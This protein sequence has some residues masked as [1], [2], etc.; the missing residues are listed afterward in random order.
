MTAGPATIAP[1]HPSSGV[2]N[3]AV[4][5]PIQINP[6]LSSSKADLLHNNRSFLSLQG[7]S[8]SG[9]PSQASPRRPKPLPLNRR[10][11]PPGLRRAPVGESNRAHQ[12]ARLPGGGHQLGGGVGLGGTGFGFG[13]GLLLLSAGG[14]CIF[15]GRRGDVTGLVRV[16]CL[17]TLGKA[18][19]AGVSVLV[20]SLSA[21][22]AV[23][24]RDVVFECG[25]SQGVLRS[26]RGRRVR[27]VQLK[28]W[29]SKS[30]ELR[31]GGPSLFTALGGDPPSYTPRSVYA[32][33]VHASTASPSDQRTWPIQV[34]YLRPSM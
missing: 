17:I 34:L 30:P 20:I 31:R 23:L 10:T 26:G 13:G 11:V 12:D 6:S 25:G 33:S 22:E 29:K 3:T 4:Q 24:L 14:F 1:P 9:H 8:S 19:E 2:H 5:S 7:V 15:E 16:L 21:C 28:G 27:E 18:M 32:A